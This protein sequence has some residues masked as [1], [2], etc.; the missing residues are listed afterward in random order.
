MALMKDNV[1]EAQQAGVIAFQRSENQLRL[2]VWHKPESDAWGIPKGFVD[3]G[4]T[5][6][7]T[8]LNEA[9]EEVGLRGRL[10][11]QPIGTYNY[12]K[13]GSEFTVAIYLMDV[14]N[15]DEDWAEKSF[16]ERHWLSPDEAREQL[17][18]HPV[19]RLLEHAIELLDASK[20]DP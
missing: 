6:P 2:C 4:D 8:A 11:G 16:R 18:E 15:Q 20:A 5:L 9:S 14:T 12:S 10:V 7:Q 13:W 19:Q 17:R 1:N 3:P